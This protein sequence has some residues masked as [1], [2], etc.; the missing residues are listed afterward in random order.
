MPYKIDI[1]IGSDNNTR[2]IGR[3][4]LEKLENWASKVFPTGYTLLKGKGFYNGISEDS[5]IVT[6]L[7]PE[8]LPLKGE[9]EYLKRAL[10]QDA[11]LLSKSYV[12]LEVF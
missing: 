8:N 11:I 3:D 9:I 5:V 1:Y 2:K 12:D 4:Y 6:V 7:S 10:G